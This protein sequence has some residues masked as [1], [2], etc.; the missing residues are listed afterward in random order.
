MLH[1]TQI[2]H[3]IPSTDPEIWSFL[4][5]DLVLKHILCHPDTNTVLE[6]T[7]M[8]KVQTNLSKIICC[9]FNEGFSTKHC[10]YSPEIITNDTFQFAF[11]N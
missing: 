5:G 11:I 9:L 6:T 10:S 8:Y 1:T 2:K 3:W 7:L 4:T